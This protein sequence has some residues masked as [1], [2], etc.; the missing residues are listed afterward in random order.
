MGI[1]FR[2]SDARTI[3][4]PFPA[5]LAVAIGDL[6]YWDSTTI[7]KASQQADQG[8][9]PLNQALFASK[10]IGVSKDQRLST[11]TTADDRTI[12]TDTVVD[13]TCPSSTWEIGDLVGPSENSG[14]DGLE[15]QQVEKVTDPA[16]AIGYCIKREGSAVTTVRCRL[17]SKYLPGSIRSSFIDLGDDEP[18]SLGNSN[19]VQL[20]WSTAD[21]DNH[22]SVLALGDTNQTLHVTDVGAKATD[23]NVAAKTHPTIAIHSNTTPATDYIEIGNHDATNAKINV[24]SGGLLFQL[25]GTTEMTLAA[26]S[27]TLKD[28]FNIVLNATTG[29]KIGTATTQKLGFFNAAPVVQPS[30]YTQTYSTAD[31]T[32]ANATQ[33]ALTHSVGTADG[34]VDD[35]GGAF[36]QTTLNNNFKEL[37]TQ[38]ENARADVLDVKQLLNSVIDDLQSLGLAG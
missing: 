12:E 24:A 23:W 35:V 30:A 13:A 14:G 38:L 16:L 34:T 8:T 3:K 10:F 36:N 20:L 22:S 28:A 37:T 18:L 11:E 5:S 17:M 15:N 1:N 19:D 32:H 9:E 7:K 33:T 31:K 29:T 6:L 2:L 27:L 26:G 25:D 21:A 4:A